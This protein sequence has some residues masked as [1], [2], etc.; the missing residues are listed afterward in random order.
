MDR[1]TLAEFLS[2][3]VNPDESWQGGVA[4]LAELIGI[5]P[6]ESPGRLG[7]IL[8]RCIPSELVHARPM[9]P[10]AGNPLDQFVTAMLE[11]S[12]E[13]NVTYRPARIDCNDRRLAEQLKQQLDGSGTVVHFRAKMDAWNAF[14]LDVVDRLQSA[15]PPPLPSLREAGCTDEQ[16]I[17]FAAAAADFY[18]ATL[19][20]LLDDTDLIQIETPRPPKNMKHAVVLGAGSQSYGLGLYKDAEDHYALMAQQVD[21]RQTTLFSFTYESPTDTVSEDVDLWKELDLPLE[22]GEAFPDAN[23]FTP[24]GPRRPTPK[25]VDFL[26]LVLKGLAETSE[27]ELDTGRW[28]KWIEVSGKRKKCVFSIPNLLDPPDHAEWMRRGK[29]PDHRS[30]EVHFEQVQEF[31]EKCGPDMS[32]DELNE[33]IN[34]RFTGRSLDDYELP[35]NT[36]AER[37]EAL[38]QEALQSFGRRRLL[39]AREALAEDPHHIKASILLAES[40]RPVDRRIELFQSAQ[41]AAAEALGSDM[42]ELAGN[43]WGFHETRPYMRACH[44]LA[45][46]LADAGQL[47]D[48][49]EQYRE[50]LRLNPNDNQGVR[51]EI[52]PLLLEQDRD[53]EAMAVLDEYPEETA[54]WLYMKALVEFRRSGRSATAKKALRAAFKANPHVLALMQSDEPPLMPETYALGSPEEA[55]ICLNELE[56]V[57]VETEGYMELMIQESISWERDRA[58]RLRDKKR[59]KLKQHDKRKRRR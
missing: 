23:L 37:A 41:R 36:A 1:H 7:L 35:R 29:T 25:E 15:A 27:D 55:A 13:H 3:P 45:V 42:A 19:W 22:T 44:G 26:T 20:E 57:W 8:W 30:H 59:R 34:A 58:K 49:I 47:S 11:L 14:V 9:I 53:T 39:L 40:M 31:I 48:A 2:L 33:A 21:P 32:L 4:D 43:F 10:D 17:Q 28:S 52:I 50:M 24:D 16:V 56:T 5:P 38:F 6:E 46:A 51:Y 54:L 18:R 12:K